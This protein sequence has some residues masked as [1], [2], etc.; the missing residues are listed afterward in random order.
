[1]TYQLRAEFFDVGLDL[2]DLGILLLLIR[3]LDV[4]AG[5]LLLGS[6]CAWGRGV[7]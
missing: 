6:R 4:V 5:G 3:L 7:N 2:L 1:M